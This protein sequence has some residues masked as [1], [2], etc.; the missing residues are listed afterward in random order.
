MLQL[1]IG[2]KDSQSLE[3]LDAS[4]RDRFKTLTDRLARGSVDHFA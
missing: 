4:L 2:A 1:F 3:E